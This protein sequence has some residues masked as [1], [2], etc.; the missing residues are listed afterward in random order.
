MHSLLFLVLATAV[1]AADDYTITV[2]NVGIGNQW[3]AG[4]ITPI[5]VTVSSN[6]NIAMTAWI[7]WEVPD[8]DG[9]MVLWGR[10]LT[11]APQG[12]TST[13]LHAP[14]QPWNTNNTTWNIRLRAWEN[15]KPTNELLLHRFS[16]ASVGSQFIEH[17][18]GRIAVFGNRRVG[19]S[20]LLPSGWIETKPE[21]TKVVSGLTSADLPDAW[22]GYLS[23]NA[24]VWA[25]ATPQ[26]SYRQSEAL[27]NWIN[28]GG[29]LIISIPT[30]GN[31]WSFGTQN[32]PLAALLGNMHPTLDQAP[33]SSMHNILGRNNSWQRVDIPI[34]VL[35]NIRDQ[36]ASDFTPLLWLDDGRVIAVQQSIGYGAVTVIGVDLTNGKLASQGL[37]EA[38]VLWNR[39]LGRRADA[40]SQNTI[41]QLKDADRW[42]NVAFSENNLSLGSLA[43]QKIA[44]STTAGGRL[45]TVFLLI[46]SYWLIGCPVGYYVFAVIKNN[47]GHGSCLQVPLSFL[48]RGLGSWLQP[49]VE[50]KQ[51]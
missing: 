6:A 20:G 2:N 41:Q 1:G 15:N 48:L 40:P 45:G 17:T 13:W 30:I 18:E 24:L 29:H 10:Q 26:F 47:G 43:E 19:L 50:F 23:L 12:T 46:F 34:H 7:Q 42:S 51:H 39:V 8:A 44:M 5:N 3:R 36:W 28:R 9:D 49:R 22:Q 35:G 11:L 32:G 33:L 14:T 38:D 4:D 27:M 37:P 21:A 16:P 25:D 31:P